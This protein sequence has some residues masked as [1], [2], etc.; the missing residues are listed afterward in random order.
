MGAQPGT[1]QPGLVAAT[2]S[3]DHTAP[4]STITSPSPGALVSNG[5]AVT[6]TGTATDGGGGVVAGVEVSVDGGQTWHPATGRASWSYTWVPDGLGSV[7][8]KSRAVDDSGNLEVPSAGTTVST[9]GPISLWSNATVPGTLNDSDTSAIEVGVK[10][11]SSVAGNILGLRFYKGPAN[12]VT[13]VGSLWA[14]NGTLL[15]QATFTNETASGW[16]QVNF[17]APVA[18]SINTIYVASYHTNIGRYS[19]DDYYFKNHGVT[20]VPLNAPADGVNGPQGVYALGTTSAFPT[21]TFASA[22]Y[23]VD[24]LFS[25]ASSD[26]TPPS[27]PTNLLA[28]GSV[29][30]ASLTWTASTDNVGVTGYNVYRS[31]ISGFTPSSSNLVGS[32]TLTSFTNSGLAAGT[33]YY[34]VTALDAAG[35]MSAPSNQAP[36]TVTADT[37]PPTVALTAPASNATVSGTVTISANA[38]DNVAVASVQFTLDGSPLGSPVTAAPYNLSW[39]T[40]TASNG[41]HTLGAIARDTSGNQANATT[42][43][44]TVSNTGPSG[45]VAAYSLDE[46][47]GTTANDASGK[48]NTGTIV[49]ATWVAGKYGSAL[50]FTGATNSMVTIANAAAISLTTGMT[51]EAWVNPTSLTSPGGNWCAAISKDHVNSGNDISYALYAA[52]GTNTPPAAHIL[53]GNTDYGAQGTSVLSLNTWTFL[54]ATYDG[55]TLKMYV[56]GTLVGSTTIGGSIFTTTDPLHIGGDWDSEVFNGSVDNARI[57]NAALSQSQ[58]TTDMNTGVGAVQPPSAPGNLMA[59]GSI[60]TASLTWTASVGNVAIAGYTIYRSTTSG[61]TPSA[62]NQ[63]GQTTAT[64]Y[65]DSGLA[66]ATYYYLVTAQDTA[67]NSSAP[68]NQA[69]ATVTADTTPPTVAL[70]APAN[71]A[72]VSGTVTVSANA[73]DNVAV[74]G[75]QFTLD[76]TNL[77]S[78]VTTA[79]YNF[80]WNSTT[81]TNG[82]HTLGAIAFDTSG[83]QA[84]AATVSVTVSNDKTPPTVALT[85]PANGATVSGTVTVSAN[86]SDNVAVAS[87]QFT[88]D[89]NNLGSAVATAPYTLSWNSTTATN[90]THTLGAIAVDTSG[91]QASATTVSVTVSNTTPTGLVAAYSLDEGSGTTAGDSSGNNNTG[92]I[93]NATWVAGKYGSALKFTGATNSFATIPDATSLDLTTGMTL[94]AWVNPTSLTSPANNWCAAISKDHVNSSNDVSYALYAASGTR[95]PPSVHILVGSTDYGAKGTSVLTLNT[96][97]F[98]AATY[99]G[100]TLRMYVNGTQ[101][102]TKTIN[103]SIFTTADPLHIGGDWSGEMFTGSIDNVRVY[104]RALTASQ[105]QTDMNT[106]ISSGQSPSSAPTPNLAIIGLVANYP[107]DEG[108]GTTL[109][110]SSGNN[111]AGAIADATWAAGQSGPALQFTGATDSMVTVPDA[112]SLHLT[113]GMTLEAWINPTTLQSHGKKRI[114]VIAKDFQRSSKHHKYPKDDIVSYALYAADGSKQAPAVHIMVDGTDYEAKGTSTLS[115]NQWTFLAAT[116]DGTTLKLYVNGTLAGSQAIQGEI[117]NTTDPLRI[118]GDWTQEMFTGLI[119]Q[120]RI[121][122]MALTQDQIQADMAAAAPGGQASPS[123]ALAATPTGSMTVTVPYGQASSPGAGAASLTSSM[124]V[125]VSY[126]QASPSGAMAGTSTSPSLSPVA[127]GRNQTS[128]SAGPVF[129]DPLQPSTSLGIRPRPNGPLMVQP[130]KNPFVASGL[131]WRS[132]ITILMNP[133]PKSPSPFSEES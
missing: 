129:L 123:G 37:T 93:T 30:T 16:Q 42:V 110:D 18:I 62:A 36:A 50:K 56:N 133:K 95:K 132:R 68:S 108:T 6:I 96:W 53:V 90:G 15:A 31:T 34:L 121:C 87:V 64:S 103:G 130:T 59:T 55:T 124:T 10:F 89:G 116:Y 115:T 43:A 72:T 78:R 97:T 98:L 104:N 63:V 7:T 80:A 33:Y 84:S 131:A 101:V 44:V 14:A 19:S 17:S 40:T 21:Q 28:T 111:N 94:E 85:A 49:N 24:V 114:A 52:T 5:T 102:G 79:P 22:N 51:L 126:G 54:A 3:T 11:S 26:T 20:N 92:A 107:T 91:N 2:A 125:A 41:S 109:N 117:L 70:T 81:A 105:I 118:G 82:T 57:Y 88:L 71:N 13:H 100:T 25:P 35:N 119:D 1:L 47:S 46:G 112:A 77:G 60:G 76:G 4:T 27:A 9:S 48:G 66:A 73:S 45:L 128:S 74:A 83:N 8:I 32:T 12:T 67:G 75:V 120:V 58:I 61:F 113:T 39:D 127:T 86:A 65:T 23:W 38:S 122:R 106:A 69:S 29:A 99:D